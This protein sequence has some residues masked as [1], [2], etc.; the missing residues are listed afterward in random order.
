MSN[1]IARTAAYSVI[2]L[3]CLSVWWAAI[4]IVVSIVGMVT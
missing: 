2:V 3:F 1:I 4:K